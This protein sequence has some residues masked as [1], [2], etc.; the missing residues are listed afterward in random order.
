MSGSIEAMDYWL[1][2]Y[3]AY[4]YM[5]KTSGKTPAE[6]FAAKALSRQMEKE[7]TTDILPFWINRM[8]RKDG[9][10]HDKVFWLAF[11]VKLNDVFCRYGSNIDHTTSIQRRWN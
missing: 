5:N 2:L 1:Y 9:G 8:C 7:L 10:F 6:L 11:C 3:V 4:K